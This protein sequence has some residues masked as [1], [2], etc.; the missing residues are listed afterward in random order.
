MTDPEDLLRAIQRE[1]RDHGVRWTV[2]G[3]HEAS[4]D[5]LSVDEIEAALVLPEAEVIEDYPEDSRG[6][7]CLVLSRIEGAR[8]VHIV[9]SHP[10]EP[11]V[12]TIYLPDA[13]K[14]KT[15]R[16]RRRN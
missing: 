3:V 13:V 4:A 10:P 12:I 1:I 15:P 8:P 14:W 9:V 2:H 16:E 5:R 7:S 6:P 11:A